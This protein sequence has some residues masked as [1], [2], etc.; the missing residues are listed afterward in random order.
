M[1]VPL[2]CYRHPNRETYVSCSECGRGICPD[3]MAFAPVGIRCPEHASVG[4]PKQSAA[5]TMRQ[6]RGTVSS[7][8]APITTVLIAINVLVYLITVGQGGGVSAPGGKLFENGALYGPL[9]ADGDWW[10][11]FTA[12]FLHASL[13]HIAF[14]MFALWLFGSVVER[15]VGPLR[16]VLVYVASGLAGSAGA[17][18]ATPNAVT[19]GAS[20]AIFGLL[21]ALL[22]LEYLQTGSFAGQAMGL[23]VINLALSFAIPNISIGGHIG[24]LIGGVIGMF[25]LALTRYRRPR[26]L[27]PAIVVAVAVASVVVAVARVRNYI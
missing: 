7:T 3:C 26:Y 22:V 16:Y 20:G 5:R 13:L 12:M 1:D 21:G 14:N 4:T 23:I 18:I 10:R 9:V 15:S 11:L 19:V 27:G 25:G 2:H 17:L 6:V 8:G 24:G